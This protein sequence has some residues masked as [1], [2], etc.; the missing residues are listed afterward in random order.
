MQKKPQNGKG[1]IK[2]RKKHA[3]Q[4]KQRVKCQTNSTAITLNVNRFNNPVRR[5]RLPDWKNNK[6]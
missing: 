5:Q 4:T 6:I 1:E 2:E 3:T